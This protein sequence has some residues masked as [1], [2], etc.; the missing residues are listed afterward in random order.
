VHSAANPEFLN[1]SS[2]S[3]MYIH[4]H[5][6][7]MFSKLELQEGINRARTPSN[8]LLTG[9]HRLSARTSTN[10]DNHI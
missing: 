2:E 5:T 9:I 6:L 1:I 10:I 4:P 8:E 7:K 3:H